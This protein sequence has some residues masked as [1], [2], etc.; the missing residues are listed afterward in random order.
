MAWRG[1]AE[2]VEEGGERQG[3]CRRGVDLGS[4][5]PQHTGDLRDESEKETTVSKAIENARG[6]K[7]ER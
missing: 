3:G 1:P 4:G 5:W 6:P 2:T 7:Q